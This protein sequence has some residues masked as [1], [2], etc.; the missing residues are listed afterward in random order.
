M[1]INDIRNIFDSSKTKTE[2]VKLMNININQ[3]SKS[4]DNDIL[5]YTSLI[6]YDKYSDITG[7]AFRK[8]YKEKLISKYNDNSNFCINCGKKLDFSKRFNK[9]C[10]CHCSVEYNNKLRIISN[11]TKLKISNSLKNK[12]HKIYKRICSQCGKEFIVKYTKS[13]KLSST[14]FCC[15]NCKKLYVGNLFRNIRKNEIESGKFKGWKSRNITSYPERFFENVLNNN[16]IPYIKE[17]HFDKYFLDFYIIK[18][19]KQIDLKIDGKQH[20]FRLEHDKV[21]DNFLSNNGIIVYRIKWNNINTNEGSEIMKNKI[22]EFLN[23]YNNM[24]VV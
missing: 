12:E 15:N 19:N 20:Q 22:N 7:E 6:G 14:K 11:N 9:F 24:G 21:R 4:I 1:N 3:N 17:Y 13:G 18:D 23:W 16:N 2:F 5:L 10:N 8:R